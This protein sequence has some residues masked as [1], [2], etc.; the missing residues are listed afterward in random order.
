MGIFKE[1]EIVPDQ[2]WLCAVLGALWRR[3]PWS[4]SPRGCSCGT[5]SPIA[6][7]AC[8]RCYS[9]PG[10]SGAG[11]TAATGWR[12]LARSTLGRRL[13]KRTLRALWISRIVAASQ[14][15]GLGYPSL[16]SNLVKCQVEL[17]RKALAALAVHL[18][19]AGGLYLIG[20]SPFDNL[21]FR[22]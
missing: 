22:P 13:K 1:G 18:Q 3:A 8:R 6:S 2:R 15:H 7:G 16:V 21:L 5:A 9:K 4:S 11:R 19:G 14:E 12:A 20:I 17:N 10:T